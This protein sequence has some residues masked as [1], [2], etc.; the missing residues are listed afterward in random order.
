MGEANKGSLLL[1]PRFLL[2]CLYFMGYLAL[3]GNGEIVHQFVSA[4]R[5]EGAGR[6]Y[7][8][9]PNPEVP[10]WRRQTY[11]VFFSPMM[12]AEEEG[13]RL[14]SRGRGLLRDAEEYGRGFM[15]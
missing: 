10:R 5:Q 6:E 14:A 11:R 3:R 7:I 12:V 15:P 1:R 2:F 4:Q 8:V 9:G 13:R